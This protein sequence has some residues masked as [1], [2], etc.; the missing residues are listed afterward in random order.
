MHNKRIIL[1]VFL[2][3]ISLVAGAWFIWQQAQPVE[4]TTLQGSGSVEAVEVI[5]SPEIS[6][7]VVEVLAVEG[8]A[9]LAGDAL[10]RLDGA[11]LEAQQNQAETSLAAT[12]AGLAVAESGQ[13]VAQA[14]LD[15]AQIQYELEYNAA[16]AQTQAARTAAWEGRLPSEF[17]LPAW[18]FT[19]DEALAASQAEM[20]AA[21]ADL[22]AEQTDLAS[23]T[24][25]PIYGGLLEGE[26]RLAEAQTAY[27]VADAVL[28][29][30][31]QQ[32]DQSLLDA[33]QAAFD[34]AEAEL[35]A[36]QEGYNEMLITETAA[37]LMEARAQLAIAQGR[38]DTARDGFNAMQTGEH[39]LRVQAAAGALAQARANV[40][41]AETRVLQAQTAIDQA[42]AQLDL[43]DIQ[44]SRLV[45]YAAVDGVVL[46]RNIEPGEVVQPGAA[47]LT[48]AR[49]DRLTITVYLP[50]DRYGVV[51]L[52][53]IAEVRVD[54]FPEQVFDATVVHIAD[55]AEFTPRNVST[56]AGRRTT[57]FAVEL[58]VDDP[59]GQLKPGMPA[60][61]KF[62]Q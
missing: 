21:Q 42:Q 15:T 20:R 32:S 13:A 31:Q 47:A 48:L 16:L 25:E 44:L 41:Q 3:V 60:D 33:A 37:N 11:Y 49:L 35:Q 14:A 56:D 54:S 5:V 2:L 30:S 10:F 58:T 34:S 4:D 9:V 53:E 19:Q 38:L 29:L 7:R 59:G 26:A 43:L 51:D 23:L 8:Q 28:Q 24:A 1:P 61:V 46:S 39:S 50:E 6:G 57:V 22:E 52:G 12:Q 55:Q 40:T 18:Y 62:D 45:V 27:L 36:A 17:T